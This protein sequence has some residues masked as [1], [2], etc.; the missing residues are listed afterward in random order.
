[1]ALSANGVFGPIP[2][3][4]DCGKWLDALRACVFAFVPQIIGMSA[5]MANPDVVARWLDALLY[6]TTFRPVQLKE[7][8]K[9]CTARGDT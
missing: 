8:V 3:L 2:R 4:N 7:Y 6:E 5:T 9:V 1:M